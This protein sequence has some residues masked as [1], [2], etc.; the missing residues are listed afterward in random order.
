M[1]KFVYN[2]AKNT[3]TSNITFELNSGYQ[4]CIFFENNTDL[5]SKSCSIEEL[6]KKLKNLIS[7]C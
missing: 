6:I 7:I 5:H 1:T 4:P 2:N 3:N